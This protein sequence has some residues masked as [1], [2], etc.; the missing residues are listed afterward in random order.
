MS[1]VLKE[2]LAAALCAIGVTLL[3]IGLLADVSARYLWFADLITNFRVHLLMVLIVCA[4]C[5]L[6][7]RRK[8]ASLVMVVGIAW[9]AWP[10]APYLKLPGSNKPIEIRADQVIYRLMSYNIKAGNIRYTDVADYIA[11]SNVD[12]VLLLETDKPWSDEMD[13]ELRDHFPHRFTEPKS[14]WQG[15][16]FYSKH[17]WK[18]APRLIEGLSSPTLT[19]E[20]ELANGVVR[21]VGVHPVPP[22]RPAL[23]KSRNDLLSMVARNV[24]KNKYPT[25]VAG[26]FNATPWSPH[27]R[28]FASVADLSDSA[29][30]RGLQN[31]WNRYP[32]FVTG[33]PIDHVLT[34][35]GITVLTRKIGPQIGS[36]HRPVVVDF[37]LD[38]K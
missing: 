33:L 29:R 4:L 3:A 9:L 22:I 24:S 23:S 34:S 13:F 5:L 14:N 37:V 15:I 7:L 12:F 19:V 26:D 11:G 21:L 36:D 6:F 35:T 8:A 28:D 10:L 31:T 25:I 20:L 32:I 16:T 18:T 1:K 38:M 30:G 17:P 2:N 27:F